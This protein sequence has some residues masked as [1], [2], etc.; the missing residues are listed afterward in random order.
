MSAPCS[1]GVI[2]LDF[3]GKFFRTSEMLWDYNYHLSSHV[4]YICMFI[5]YLY[6][7]NLYMYV[8]M[9]V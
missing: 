7:I 8:C 5:L 2:K 6:K 1:H 3:E 9:C 4:N